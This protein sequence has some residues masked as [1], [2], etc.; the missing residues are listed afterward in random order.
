MEPTNAWTVAEL[1]DMTG[2]VVV[3]TGGAGLYGRPIIAALAEMGAHVVVA[4]RDVNA[5]EAAAGELTGHSLLASA[6]ALDLAD[7]ASIAAL[8]ATV[9]DDFGAFD[10]LVNNAVHRSGATIDTTTA[11][12][13]RSTSDVNSLGLFLMCKHAAEHMT[14]HG[15]R[16][17][18]STSPASTASSVPPSTSTTGRT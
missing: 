15:D 14:E 4:A 8:S 5:C 9:V 2:R 7:E 13:W 10:V 6:R 1:F 11:E 17:S 18:S 3:V 16:A 12:D